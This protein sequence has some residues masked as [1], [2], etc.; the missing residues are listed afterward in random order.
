MNKIKLLYKQYG[1]GVFSRLFKSLLLKFNIIN[2]KLIVFEK[3]IDRNDIETR[4]ANLDVSDVKTLNLEDFEFCDLITNQKKELYKNRF[5]SGNYVA[6]GIFKN[7]KLV[8]YSWISWNYIGY[9]FGFK[10]T[11]MELSDALLEDSFCDPRYRGLGFH[12]KVNIVRLKMILEKGKKNVLAIVLIGNKP[13]IKVQLKS[14]FI[15]TKTIVLRK[16][17]SNSNT[18]IKDLK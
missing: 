2:E 12:G 9:P 6:I 8:Y 13:A 14:G 4:L 15:Q 11:K 5:S 7:Q 16:I 1:L 17:F 3:K 10:K 18:I